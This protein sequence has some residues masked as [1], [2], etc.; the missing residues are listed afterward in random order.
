MGILNDSTSIAKWSGQI[1]NGRNSASGNSRR[2][3]DERQRPGHTALLVLS[4]PQKPQNS[5]QRQ[6]GR[7]HRFNISRSWFINVHN[8]RT[9]A[10][11]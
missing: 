11:S 3:L 10:P 6:K 4:K 7:G 1:N 5:L 9:H 2:Q 8:A